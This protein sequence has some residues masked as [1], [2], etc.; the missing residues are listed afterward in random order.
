[1]LSYDTV[2]CL[3]VPV[4]VTGEDGAYLFENQVMRDK[5]PALCRTA[6][7][8]AL[9]QVGSETLVSLSQE[10]GCFLTCQW[11]GQAYPFFGFRGE[12]VRALLLFS[13]DGGHAAHVD[14]G[15]RSGSR[16]SCGDPR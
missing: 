10:E 4:C 5:L 6:A 16:L 9:L 8:R 11:Q 7:K 15:G 12:R 1:M 3:G 2:S 14:S 13:P